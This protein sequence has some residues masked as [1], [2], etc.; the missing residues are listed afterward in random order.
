[1]AKLYSDHRIYREGD[2]GY[3]WV[4][5]HE[6]IPVFAGSHKQA[7]EGILQV[8]AKQESGKTLATRLRQAERRF[9]KEGH[10]L[11]VITSDPIRIG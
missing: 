1:M 9:K 5:V 7:I 6:G 2:F 8:M 4:T 10:S 11:V 3:V